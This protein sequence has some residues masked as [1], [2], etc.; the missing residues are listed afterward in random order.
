M[1]SLVRVCFCGRIASFGVLFL[2]AFFLCYFFSLSLHLFPHPLSPVYRRPGSPGGLIELSNSLLPLSAG[3]S[4]CWWLSISNTNASLAAGIR[5]QCGMAALGS[6]L[7][8]LMQGRVI[9][10]DKS[11]LYLRFKLIEHPSSLFPMAP[12]E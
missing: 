4:Q 1:L 11:T 6:D 2:S 5:W 8:V 3:V 7:S 10:W 9:L 12:N